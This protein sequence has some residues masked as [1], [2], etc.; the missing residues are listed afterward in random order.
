MT[1]QERKK[2][3]A[4]CGEL[5]MTDDDRHTLIYGVT[6]KESV[7]ELT[8]AE[9]RAVIAELMNR[10]NSEHH[11]SAYKS[12]KVY[13][14]EGMTQEQCRKAFALIYELERY[15]SENSEA[16]AAQRLCGAIKKFC[17]KLSIAGEPF[18]RLNSHDGIILIEAIN[19]CV[20]S[21][22]KKAGKGK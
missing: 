17:K 1:A 7:R 22:E 9:T 2:I 18:A 11:Q 15:D 3:F 10:A 13:K 8:A 16:N 4:L 14:T 6:G 21:A 20:R 19:G 12:K 5:E